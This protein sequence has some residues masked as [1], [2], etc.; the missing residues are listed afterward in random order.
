MTCLAFCIVVTL[1]GFQCTP[2][3]SNLN[4]PGLGY[5]YYALAFPTNMLC[6]VL[7]VARIVRHRRMLR[8]LGV[9]DDEVT[10]R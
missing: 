5:S 9:V 3:L 6:T 4:G 1:C 7:I 10:T 2:L 8:R